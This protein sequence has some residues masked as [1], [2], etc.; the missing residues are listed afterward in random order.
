M[1]G[2]LKDHILNMTI[3]GPIERLNEFQ[4][5]LLQMAKGFQV[6][7]T[8]SS[9]DAPTEKAPVV[10]ELFHEPEKITPVRKN[11]LTLSEAAEYLNLSKATLYRYTSMRRI[12]FFRVGARILMKIA[13]LDAWLQSK[14]VQ[15]G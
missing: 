11:I 9:I 5:V 15:G 8:D 7:I 12:P 1:E 10:V 3:E 4:G 13:D 2:K 14:K 6:R